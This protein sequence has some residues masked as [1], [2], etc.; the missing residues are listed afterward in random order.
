MSVNGTR[1]GKEYNQY[2]MSDGVYG[3]YLSALYY[4]HNVDIL[5]EEGFDFKFLG[6]HDGAFYKSIL[7]GPTCDSGDKIV[8]NFM[9]PKLKLGDYIY[10]ANTGAYSSATS[11]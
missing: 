1:E 9:L 11:T 6:K 7:W 10:S 2:Y 3:S 8:E 4:N 5:K